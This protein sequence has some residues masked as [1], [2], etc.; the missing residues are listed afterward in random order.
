MD[1]YYPK[2]RDFERN[3]TTKINYYNSEFYKVR[4]LINSIEIL[5]ED[6]LYC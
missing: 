6:L 2:A 3:L 5:I 4:T 1:I